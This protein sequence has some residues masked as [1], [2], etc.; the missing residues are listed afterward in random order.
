MSAAAARPLH[1]R[2]EFAQSSPPVPL[3]N[4]TSKTW[5]V[6]M[7]FCQRDITYENQVA[8]FALSAPKSTVAQKVG[9]LIKEEN[10]LSNDLEA[11]RFLDIMVMTVAGGN[12]RAQLGGISAG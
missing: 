10:G 3:L 4:D 11:H 12:K 2:K 5:T 9:Q 1:W 7:P 8:S 6:M